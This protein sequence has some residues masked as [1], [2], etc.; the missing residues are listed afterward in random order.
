MA[1]KDILLHVDGGSAAPARLATAVELAQA[2]G[3]HLTGLCLAVE[4]RVP[5]TMLGMISPEL[6]ADRRNAV[7]EQAEAD[8]AQFRLAVEAAGL[9]GE[10]RIVQV[11]DIDAAGVFIQHARHADLSILCQ[12][13]PAAP[14]ALG[15]Q[16]ATNVLI[17]SGR[18]AIVIPHVGPARTFGERILVAWD[19]GRE[20]TR[21]VHD[22]LPLLTR[23]RSVTVLSVNPDV[24]SN[25]GRREPGADISRHL[26]RHGAHVTAART[27]AGEL[28]VGDAI[29]ADIGNNGI[30]LLVMGAYGHS[31]LREFVLGGVTRHM[32]AHMTVPVLMSH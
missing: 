11:V 5:S 28:S 31:R 25:G 19:G 20:A 16:F 8:T 29:L 6:L 30:D 10:G 9:P 15:S 12:P 24:S 14:S 22:A 13:D 26:A 3:A 23:A 1:I 27:I 7:L 21:A 17:G 4:P 2:H 32:L 18:P